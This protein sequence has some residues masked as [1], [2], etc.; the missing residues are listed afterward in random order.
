[1][2]QIAQHN[3]HLS[4]WSAEK[5]LALAQERHAKQQEK[6]LE[7][8]KKKEKQGTNTGG[9]DKKRKKQDNASDAIPLEVQQN[10]GRGGFDNLYKTI[11]VKWE[12]NGQ[13]SWFTGTVIGYE[14]LT[15]KHVIYYAESNEEENLELGVDIAHDEYH[16]LEAPTPQK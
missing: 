12:E 7:K 6:L 8:Q 2:K 5:E 15:N 4:V 16:F 10:K 9:A 13:V 3:G 11:R 14:P 1:M